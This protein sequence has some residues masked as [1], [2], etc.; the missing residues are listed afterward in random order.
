MFDA[1]S[2]AKGDLRVKIKVT[3]QKGAAHE[4]EAVQQSCDPSS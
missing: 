3:D 4:I 1:L 2:S